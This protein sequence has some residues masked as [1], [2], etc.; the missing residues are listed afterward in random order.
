MYTT[1]Q[2]YKTGFPANE[3]A[4][5]TLYSINKKF[6]I[7]ETQCHKKG[8]R[9]FRLKRKKVRINNINENRA[10]KMKEVT[11]IFMLIPLRN[12]GCLKYRISSSSVFSK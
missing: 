1:V 11:K 7:S 2:L 9:R 3:S 6:Y 12:K 5:T 10:V 8:A 4:K